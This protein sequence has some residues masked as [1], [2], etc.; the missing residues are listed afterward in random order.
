MPLFDEVAVK[1]Y[2]PEIEKESKF[3]KYFPSMA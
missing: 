2:W 1:K 3:S